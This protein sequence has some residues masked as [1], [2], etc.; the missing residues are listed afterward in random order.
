MPDVVPVEIKEDV[1]D[2]SVEITKKESNDYDEDQDE[3]DGFGDTERLE[4]VLF[5]VGESPVCARGGCGSVCVSLH[6]LWLCKTCRSEKCSTH[7]SINSPNSSNS[8]SS[9][10]STMNPSTPPSP[11]PCT[12]QPNPPT[13]HNSQ[14]TAQH[15]STP[16]GVVGRGPAE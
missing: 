9:H 2:E 3:E 1:S 6:G 7:E 10:E 15:S 11:H 13:T 5:G 12:N 8:S 4:T 16:H 14:P